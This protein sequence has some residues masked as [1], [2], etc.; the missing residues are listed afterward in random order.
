MVKRL[1]EYKRQSLKL[2]HIVSLYEQ[3]I[4]GKIA[5]ADVTPRTVVFGAKAAPGYKM[6]KETI[7]LINKVARRSTPTSV[8]RDASRWPSP[9][10][11]TSRWP[12]S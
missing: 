8:S 7:H 2:L 4:S 10:T 3:V 6:A 1:H 12:R 5:A 9:P 11:T